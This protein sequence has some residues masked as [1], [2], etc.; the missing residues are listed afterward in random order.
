MFKIMAIMALASL[1]LTV[2]FGKE[3]EGDS[4]PNF[5]RLWNFGDP[6]GT[7]ARFRELIPRAVE[8]GDFPYYAEL[9]TQIA[10]TQGLQGKFDEAH[11]SLDSAEKMITEDMPRANIR[12]LLERGRVYNSSGK[13]EESKGYFM[14]AWDLA[15]EADEV[16]L[17]ID[18]AHMMGIVEPP[19]KQLEWS[20]K[21]LDLAET[22]ENPQAKMWLGALY[23]NI[24]WT[25]HDMGQFENAL[26]LFQ[27]G[28]DWRIEM[29]SEPE[30]RI[31]KWSVARALR[32]LDRIDEALT[33]QT[34][35]EAEF[36]EKGL[37]TD[38]YCLEEL[39]E[40]YLIKGDDEKA[41]GYFAKA[42]E[43]LSQDQWLQQNEPDRLQRLKKL[44]GVE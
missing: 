38:G 9:I 18:A 3:G 4:L 35:L 13:A 41:E 25:Y 31:A 21:A 30:I 11:A 2:V 27:K 28:L 22:S 40:L 5:D 39:G 12:Y 7:E 19:E 14:Q 16:G 44:G 24:G 15:K 32:S 42:Y 36:T 6:A 8:S 26:E 20:L 29:K 23:N 33:I 37:P 17:A 34:E 1:L 10:R 43:I